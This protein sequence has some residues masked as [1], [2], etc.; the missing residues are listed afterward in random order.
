MIRFSLQFSSLYRSFPLSNIYLFVDDH[1]QTDNTITRG[2]FC[3]KY[4]ITFRSD[5]STQISFISFSQNL[6][7]SN[8]C[9]SLEHTQWNKQNP[10][11]TCLSFLNKSIH[12]IAS[13]SLLFS[14]F[15]SPYYSL[16]LYVSLSLSIYISLLL[17]LSL[18]LSLYYSLYLSLIL[19]PTLSGS[20]SLF[21]S[22]S[23]SLS[24][25]HT[26]SL[27]LS[28]YIYI[29]HS[30][31]HSLRLC[32]SFFL[33]L[34]LLLSVCLSLLLSV[35]VWLSDCLSLSLSV[36]V[37]PQKSEWVFWFDRHKLR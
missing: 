8:K 26:L 21:F 14:L 29:Y 17:S 2:Q 11:R 25:S 20:V 30:F 27:S 9:P 37:W 23:N 13:L 36:C 6:S 18:S 15:L 16:P 12:T 1:L 33:S 7:R 3:G 4:R 32:L 28:L 24:L 10:I 35:C 22:L 31:S 19:S 5:Q 34:T